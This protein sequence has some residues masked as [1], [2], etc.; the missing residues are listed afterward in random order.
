MINTKYIVLI[1]DKGDVWEKATESFEKEKGY[2]LVRATSETQTLRQ[3]MLT[4]PDLVIIN[5]DELEHNDVITL[6]EYLRKTREY[7][8]TPIVMVSS[9]E[10]KEHRIDMLRRGVEFYIK[11]PLQQN[12]MSPKIETCLVSFG[13]KPRLFLTHF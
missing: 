9:S 8:I 1:D 6:V 11:K 7:A 2:N 13:V 3:A 5:E 10:D 12:V 4:I